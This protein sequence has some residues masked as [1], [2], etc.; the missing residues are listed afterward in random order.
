M[1]TDALAARALAHFEGRPDG[2]LRPVEGLTLL[3]HEA[4]TSWSPTVY[5]PVVCLILQG[6]KETAAG[7]RTVVVSAG[8]ALIVSHDLPV[9][10]RITQADAGVPYLA[11]IVSLD[12]SLL[13]RL[14]DEVGD[15]HVRDE[16]AHALAAHAADPAL[17]DALTRYLAL[18]ASPIESRV[19]LPLIRQEVH[20]RLLVAPN[21]GMLRGLL[22][23]DSHASQVARAIAHLRAHLGAAVS[24]PALARQ[25]GMSP[26]SLHKHF[27]AVTSTTPL[28]YLKE[29]RLLE[30]RRLLSEGEHGVS[31]VAYAV[32]YESPNQFSREYSRKFG[33]PPRGD[34]ARPPS[35]TARPS[36]GTVPPGAPPSSPPAP[37]P[38]PGNPR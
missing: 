33:V 14:D 24:I 36:S 37:A 4:P 5:D 18:A 2:L 27:K 23:R 6:R 38:C 31:T 29:L 32:G 12:M 21:G 8:D 11:L 13:R 28:Q 1:R 15:A 9:L 16:D 25:V 30:A 26:S 3:R 17:V 34:R 7:D 20:F 19:L 22:R 35:P 10:A